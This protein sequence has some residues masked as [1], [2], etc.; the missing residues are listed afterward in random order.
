MIVKE[1]ADTKQSNLGR[2]LVTTSH[3]FDQH[4]STEKSN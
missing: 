1:S 4:Q 3:F 2:N